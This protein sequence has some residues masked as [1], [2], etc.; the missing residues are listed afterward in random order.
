MRAWWRHRCLLLK[1]KRPVTKPSGNRASRPS[2]QGPPPQATKAIVPTLEFYDRLLRMGF[3]AFGCHRGVLAQ[4]G[5][6]SLIASLSD[7]ADPTP[8]LLHKYPRPSRR[9]LNPPQADRLPP[10]PPSCTPVHPLCA[11]YTIQDPSLS[12]PRA[13]INFGRRGGGWTGTLTGM[14]MEPWS[15]RKDNETPAKSKM[16]NEKC[17]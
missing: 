7:P 4:V 10:P 16:K 6:G 8:R 1:K 15:N 13:M 11:L 14:P 3:R 2:P 17:K 12:S 9:S 5:K